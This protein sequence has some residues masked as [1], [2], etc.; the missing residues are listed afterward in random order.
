M[1]SF[2]SNL[3]HATGMIEER[4][5]GASVQLTTAPIEVLGIEA[6]VASR[7][8]RENTVTLSSNVG[9]TATETYTI[10]NGQVCCLWQAKKHYLPHIRNVDF[11]E[12]FPL[13]N[14]SS[15]N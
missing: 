4:Q 9:T 6:V 12:D 15:E 5:T 2:S 14:D 3:E 10:I 7:Q 11:G 1:H 8:R 13:H